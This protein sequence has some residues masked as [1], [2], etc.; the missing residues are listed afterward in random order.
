[1]E[2][3]R[4]CYIGVADKKIEKENFDKVFRMLKD[5]IPLFMLD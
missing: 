5:F 2:A 1:M 3:L 4:D